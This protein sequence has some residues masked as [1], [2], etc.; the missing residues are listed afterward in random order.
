MNQPTQY[1]PFRTPAPSGGGGI[2]WIIVF[3]I[4]WTILAPVP[5]PIDDLIVW[6]FGA[7]SAMRG[8]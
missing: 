8:K 2:G 5:G 6:A 7:Y 3:C 1:Q 4:L